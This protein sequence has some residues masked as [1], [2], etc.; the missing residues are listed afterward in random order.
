MNSSSEEVGFY[1]GFE[2]GQIDAVP[3]VLGQRPPEGGGAAVENALLPQVRCLALTGR[4]RM[5]ASE[6]QTFCFTGSS[7]NHWL[8]YLS[9]ALFLYRRTEC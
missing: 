2:Q 3:G 5:L 7:R 6:E 4:D 9:I 1:L 8:H